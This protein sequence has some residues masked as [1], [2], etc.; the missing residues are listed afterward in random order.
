M[1]AYKCDRCGRLFDKKESRDMSLSKR[2]R[3]TRHWECLDLCSECFKV[4]QAWFEAE[5]EETV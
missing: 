1:T 5:K 4:L 2:N 3:V